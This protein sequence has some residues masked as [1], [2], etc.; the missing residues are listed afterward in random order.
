MTEEYAGEV[1]R[2]KYG[3]PSA[4]VT[5][6]PRLGP[7]LERIAAGIVGAHSTLNALEA[8]LNGGGIPLGSNA[9]D[10]V[11]PP[12]QPLLPTAIRIDGDV[13]HLRERL[14]KL[15]ETL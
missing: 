9:A 11:E 8:R 4:R 15:L 12:A 10:E 14:A 3:A 2:G 1:H 13:R 6:T 5:E 7:T